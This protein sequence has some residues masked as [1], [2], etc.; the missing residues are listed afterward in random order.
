MG[1]GWD[2]QTVKDGDGEKIHLE[3]QSSDWRLKCPDMEGACRQTDRRHCE[4]R[5][6]WC[7]HRFKD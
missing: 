5:G 7:K 3:E 2:G 4:D 1:G 6:T